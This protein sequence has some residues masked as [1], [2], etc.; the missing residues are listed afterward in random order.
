MEYSNPQIPEGINVTRVHPLGELF[1]LL[2]I[3]ASLLVA[4]FF[5]LGLIADWMAGRIPFEYERRWA[6]SL[7]S[8]IA[9]TEDPYLAGLAQ[10]LLA[11]SEQTDLQ[12]IVHR[13][14]GDT[15]NAF[16]TLGGHIIVYTGLLDRLPHEN[17][18][19][20]L[21]GHEIAH[22]EDR[23]PLRSLGRTVVI[24]LGVAVLGSAGAGNGL[25]D[26]VLGEAG[27]LTALDYSRGQER[28]ADVRALEMVYRLYGHVGG[29]TDLY[30]ALS[31][32]IAIPAF[33]STHPK[34]DH[35]ITRLEEIA[36]RR[37]WPLTGETVSICRDHCD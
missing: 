7:S 22:V 19:A 16:A 21:L 5:A 3:I 14:E 25:V 26:S 34:I 28:R 11:A 6:E 17:A 35:R 36:A 33:F 15:V 24:G 10:R 29:A 8:D 1:R 4:G 31:D 32:E 37:G 20:M 23:D 12:V 30:R 13:V 27:L 2:A 9:G 18:L